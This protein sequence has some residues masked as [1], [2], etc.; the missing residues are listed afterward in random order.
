MNLT[1]EQIRFLIDELGISETKL[2]EASK[3]EWNDI[4][5]KMFDIESEELLSLS[6]NGYDIDEVT[7]DRA[8]IAGEIANLMYADVFGPKEKIA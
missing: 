5:I 4:K 1:N 6:E 2:K 8:E 7:T 3:S